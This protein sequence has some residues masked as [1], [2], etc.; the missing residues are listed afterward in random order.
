MARDQKMGMSMAM[1]IYGDNRLI[2]WSWLHGPL[3]GHTIYLHKLQ[4]PI[5]GMQFFSIFQ[6]FIYVPTV[7]ETFSLRC[8]GLWK[9]RKQRK[10]ACPLWATVHTADMKVEKLSTTPRLK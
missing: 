10:A 7:V 1:C 2:T 6:I 8:K 5:R 4:W 9:S 3:P